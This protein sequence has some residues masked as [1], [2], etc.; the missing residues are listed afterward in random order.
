MRCADV[1]ERLSAYLDR[2]LEPAFEALVGSI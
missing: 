1:K 2:E